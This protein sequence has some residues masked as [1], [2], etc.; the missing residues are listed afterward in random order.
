MKIAIPV[1]EAS[2]DSTV[3]VSFARAPYF[4]YYNT[5][6]KEADFQANAAA[7]AQGGAGIKAAQAL[8]DQGAE[9]L[10]TPRCGEKA[11]DPIT[12][13]GIKIYKTTSTSI[14]EMIDAFAGGQLNILEETH[15]GLHGR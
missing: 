6:T 2:L 7:N 11:A 10:L 5:E 9:A 4:L 14:Q 8:I 12:A 13:A 1:D 15:Q 3:C